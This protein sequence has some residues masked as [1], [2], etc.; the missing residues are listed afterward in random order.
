MKKNIEQYIEQEVKLRLLEYKQKELQS[1][2]GNIHD[3]LDSLEAR[4]ESRFSILVGLIAFSIILKV[5]YV[6]FGIM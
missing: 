4:I 3:R 2:L 6:Y 1:G 5:V